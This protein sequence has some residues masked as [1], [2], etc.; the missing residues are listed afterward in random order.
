MC[1]N[2]ASLYCHC[3]CFDFLDKSTH[4]QRGQQ[5]LFHPDPL[6]VSSPRPHNMPCCHCRAPGTLLIN[7]KGTSVRPPRPWSLGISPRL[8]YAPRNLQWK[9]QYHIAPVPAW[10]L[11]SRPAA[12]TDAAKHCAGVARLARYAAITTNPR[13]SL[14]G[15]AGRRLA[16]P[17]AHGI[18]GWKSLHPT[19]LLPTTPP[20]RLIPYASTPPL[21]HS[22]PH[23]H[24]TRHIACMPRHTHFLPA[25]HEHQQQQ[26]QQLRK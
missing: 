11:L 9:G 17:L 10:P 21:P 6:R 5:I 25:K 23:P 7:T 26:Q 1:W 24:H 12:H 22:I 18:I 13:G 16:R 4:T 2:G 15:R 8:D 20:R 19:S 14:G 3:C